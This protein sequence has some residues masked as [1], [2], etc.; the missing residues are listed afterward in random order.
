MR[1]FIHSSSS[2]SVVAS[3]LFDRL[4]NFGPR[5]SFFIRQ[6]VDLE[7]SVFL[8]PLRVKQNAVRFLICRRH[9]F[10][11]SR[12]AWL[13]DGCPNA[14]ELLKLG[15]SGVVSAF[16]KRNL[17]MSADLSDARLVLRHQVIPV[18][19]NELQ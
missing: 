16:L 8:A 15:V 4:K 5:P 14:N 12:V 13:R 18:N 17:K 19:T 2:A 11:F 1:L 6:A 7:N 3:S 10:S 9:A